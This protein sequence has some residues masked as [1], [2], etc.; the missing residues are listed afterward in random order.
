[1]TGASAVEPDDGLQVGGCR[2]KLPPPRFR[3]EDSFEG[4]KQGEE[5]RCSKDCVREN[6]FHIVRVWQSRA[7]HDEESC[8]NL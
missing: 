1:M 8:D 7:N 2:A 3:V 4:D 5:Q 6:A